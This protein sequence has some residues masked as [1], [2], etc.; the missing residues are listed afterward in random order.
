[1]A[2]ATAREEAALW[3]VRMRDGRAPQDERARFAAW[4]VADPQHASEYAAFD[5]LWQDFDSTPRTQALAN[6]SRAFTQQRRRR[7][8]GGML[9]MAAMGCVGWWTH[10]W[11]QEHADNAPQF[12]L[13]RSTTPGQRMKL[14]LPDGS[15]LLLAGDSAIAATFTRRARKLIL[16]NGQALFQVSK[17]ADRPFTVDCAGTQ[18]T[19]VG[20]HFSVDRLPG[21]VRVSVQ[22]GT[23]RFAT[24]NGPALTLQAGDVAAWR[25]DAPPDSAPERL[26]GLSAADAFAIERGQIVFDMASLAE[27]AATLSRYSPTPVRI[28]TPNA[29]GPRITASVQI[30]QI[31]HFL[32]ALPRIAAVKV[33]R[34][35]GAITLSPR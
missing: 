35:E 22:E 8:V 10:R 27:I 11:W 5:A 7:V 9:S 18:V 15:K 26:S 34:A 25:D 21:S 29:I 20:T 13:A 19:V 32:D 14:E 24:A 28:A 33:Q 1:M 17:D 23:V 12:T 31:P 4:M 6:A 3:F 16:H 2:S 30:A